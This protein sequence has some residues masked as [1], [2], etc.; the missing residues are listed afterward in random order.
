MGKLL[1]HNQDF[2][3]GSETN[4]AVHDDTNNT[5]ARNATN[6]VENL[7]TADI[8]YREF[9]LGQ[10]IKS[11]EFWLLALTIFGGTGSSYMVQ[12]QLSQIITAIG[13]SENDLSFYLMIVVVV[14]CFSRIL[15]GSLQ[16]KLQVKCGVPRPLLLF[17]VVFVFGGCSQLILAYS[18]YNLHVMLLGISMSYVCF[19]ATWTIIGALVSDVVGSNHFGKIFSIVCLGGMGGIFFNSFIAGENYEK[20]YLKTGTNAKNVCC[21]YQCYRNTFMAVGII[22]FV[23]S[24]AP[25][26]LYFKMQFYKKMQKKTGSDL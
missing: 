16:D 5:A 7:S 12:Y 13:G 18:Y 20:E 23:L 10:A 21:G 14:Q 11:I 2:D 19:G 15:F 26:V 6:M 3:D 24:F 8:H 25:L 22:T 4:H 1:R 17:F 9:T